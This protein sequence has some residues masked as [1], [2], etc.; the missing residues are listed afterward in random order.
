[1]SALREHA[2]MPISACGVQCID[3]DDRV[4]ALAALA[5]A[6][7][8]LGVL[9]SYPAAHLLT[10]PRRRESVQRRYARGLL[11]CL[12]MRLRVVD[13]RGGSP[14]RA[15]FATPGD[16][17]LVVAGHVGWT[18]VLA[19]ASIQPVTFVARGDLSQ[20]PV[21]GQVAKSTRFVPIDRAR[22][23][24]LPAVID[25]VALRLRGGEGVAAFPEGTTWCG[26]TYGPLR[27]AIFQAAI[28]AGVPVQPVRLRY[29]HGSGRQTTVAGFVGD[30]TLLSS[31]VRLLRARGVVA[32]LVLAPVEQPL[33]D[34]RALAAR[35][36]RAVR[37]EVRAV[38]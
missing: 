24:E 2:W 22:L 7:A 4:T 3:D 20:W 15:R 31:V 38:S 36:E 26:R 25:L 29:V 33:G 23:R 12:G 9:A 28:D 6:A 16:G 18:D 11:S 37:G 1:V 17:V 35:C 14:P 32:E 30:D 5:R 8:A 13:E 21:I 27:P 34:R 19:I 10:P